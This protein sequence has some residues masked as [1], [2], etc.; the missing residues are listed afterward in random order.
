MHIDYPFHFDGLG[1]TATTE[2]EDYIRDL[3]EQ[4][5]LTA[6]GERVNRPEFGCGLVSHLFEPNNTEG[7]AAVG[8][9]VQSSLQQLMGDLV[10]VESLDVSAEDAVL[11]LDLQYSLRLTGERG[12]MT[13]EQREEP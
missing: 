3:I 10:N 5:L 13:V 12:E 11:R 8:I 7:A 9:A 1:S 4:L 6:P 2:D